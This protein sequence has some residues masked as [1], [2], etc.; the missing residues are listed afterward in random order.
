LEAHKEYE[1]IVDGANIALYQQNF[2]EGDFC[3]T[4]VCAT[5]HTE[6]DMFMFPVKRYVL[7][8]NSCSNSH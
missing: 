8:T 7:T 6:F 1:A 5:L 2:A 4:Q 3:L